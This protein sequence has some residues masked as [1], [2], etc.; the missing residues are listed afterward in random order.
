MRSL[1]GF[2]ATELTLPLPCPGSDSSRVPVSRCHTY[3]LPSREDRSQPQSYK[4]SARN[5]R[6][7]GAER[8]RTLNGE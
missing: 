2:Q 7:K 4:A 5:C 6:G 3:T 1:R 8:E